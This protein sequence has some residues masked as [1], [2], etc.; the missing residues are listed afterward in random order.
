[1]SLEN[2]RKNTDKLEKNIKLIP[3]KY[4]NWLPEIVKK[5]IE[6]YYKGINEIINNEDYRRKK[7]HLQTRRYLDRIKKAFIDDKMKSI[8]LKLN[9]LSEEKCGKF[10]IFLLICEC[11]RDIIFNF[12]LK[13][14]ERIEGTT[15]IIKQL[16]KT[17]CLIDEINISREENEKVFLENSELRKSAEN[18]INNSSVILDE[19]ERNRKD[20]FNHFKTWHNT[21]R[22]S[23]TE[24]G[25]P[26][27]FIREIYTYFKK[28]F[29]RPMIKEVAI[30]VNVIFDTDFKYYDISQ[31]MKNVET[32]NL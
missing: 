4:K 13:K 32:Q 12:D 18:Y 1:M 26:L 14:K 15:K 8:W 19:L 3:F 5:N 9:N 23:N 28:V 16:K 25:L 31:T 29:K 17:I 30:I 20:T 2:K 21:N 7:Y 6:N 27:F 22:Q 10:T 24:K 11:G